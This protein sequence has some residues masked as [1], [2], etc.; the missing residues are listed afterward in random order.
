MKLEGCKN[1]ICTVSAGYSSGM[2]AYYMKEWYPDHNIVF[3]YANTSK[4]HP[5]SI[6]F[7][8]AMDLVFDLGIVYLEGIVHHN[9]RKGTTHKVLRFNEVKS[10]GGV[11]EE[12][13]KKYGIPSVANKWCTR[14]LKN[15]V[16]KSYADTIF[17]KK[18]YSIA[19]GL[20]SDEMDRTAKN[21]SESNVFYPLMER[22]ITS[23]D[24]NRFWDDFGGELYLGIPAYMGN[25]E[26]CF[27]KSLRKNLTHLEQEP[28][29]SK[30]YKLMQG[31][32]SRVK[33]PNKT[34][35]NAMIDEYGGAYFF[36][37]NEKVET[38]E[39][40]VEGDFKRATDEYIYEDPLLDKEGD[41]GNSCAIFAD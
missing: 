32:Y 16:I 10:S 29:I 20:R 38:L 12:G 21:Y 22:D 19:I 39:Q 18:N 4:E 35:Y 25:C 30:W 14:E 15:N 26:L 9:R 34:Q 1:I 36:R 40:L 13:I 5:K 41:C 24:R 2:M 37:G 17:G 31:K 3:C 28:H 33:L 8:Q 11:F 27:E 6:A 23:N 7:L